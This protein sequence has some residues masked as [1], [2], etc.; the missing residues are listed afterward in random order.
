M[1]AAPPEHVLGSQEPTHRL[2]V[3]DTK[4]SR[5]DEA[6]ELCAR[7]GLELDDWQKQFLIDGCA[8]VDGYNAAG[9]PAERW[10]AE[11]VGVELS[12]QNGKSVV[13]EARVLAGLFLFG[14]ELIVYSAHEGDTAKNAFERLE[15]L[16]RSDPVLFEQVVNDGRTSGFRRTNGQLSITLWSGQI[17]KFRTRTAGGGRGLTGDCVILDESQEIT[18]D[19]IAAL[20]P[21]LSA[22]PNPQLWWGGNAGNR[23]SIVQGRMVRRAERLEPQLV[24]YRWASSDED[25]PT[26]PLTWARVNPALGRRMTLSYMR[27]EMGRMSADKFGHEHLGIGDYPRDEG[28]DW[29]IPRLRWEKAADKTSQVPGKVVFSIETKWDRMRTSICIAGYRPD[30][31]KHIECI[32]NAPGTMWAVE[33][34]K[35]LVAKHPNLGVVID[36]RSPANN[37]VPLLT[38][39][40]LAVH[41]LTTDEATRAFGNMYDALVPVAALNAAPGAPLPPP[42]MFHRGGSVMTSALAD[43]TVRQVAGAITWRRNVVADVSPILGACW[44]AEGL[45]ILEGKHEPPP[46]P[47]SAA[48]EQDT[49]SLADWDVGSIGF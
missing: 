15:G 4:Y 33:E 35:R 29:A 9:Q 37:L 26:S 17:V 8:V 12:R 27:S 6:I 34:M 42:T 5:G 46:S 43:A 19:H 21:T 18:D 20:G 47:E 40:G 1:V 10:A 28:E 2:W 16:I 45:E 14:E 38:D 44:A 3:K 24:Y 13:F 48:H 30:G 11:D 22:R 49:H 41:L 7:I 31:A 23:K 25:D 32:Y 39:A 36:P